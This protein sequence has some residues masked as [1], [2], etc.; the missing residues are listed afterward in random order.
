MGEN[1]RRWCRVVVCATTLVLAL[2][3]VSAG[4]L[5]RPSY[6]PDP[7]PDNSVSPP[8]G[9]KVPTARSLSSAVTGAGPG[10]VRVVCQG[11]RGSTSLSLLERSV[12]SARS[13]GYRLRPSQPEIQ[14]SKTQARELLDIN[15]SLARRCAFDSIQA[16]VNASGNNDR[17]VIM[18]GTYTEPESRKA[19]TNDPRCNPS[20]LQRDASGDPTPSYAYQV[21]CPNDQNLVFVQGRAVK[22]EPLGTPREDRQGIP[23]QELG[24]CVRCNFQIEGS[25]VKPEDVIIDAG[26]DYEGSGPEARPRDHAKHVALRA[27][28]AD[29]FVGR[30]ILMRGAS[31]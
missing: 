14:L 21:A 10:D 16:A 22:G 19:P 5:E 6:W 11:K 9:G 2:P 23:E 15:R 4:H 12:S 26:L 8:A 24:A 17:V 7:A 20:L 13:N 31:G 18:P 29:G 3:S 30:N 28:R 1:G 27:D 25:G